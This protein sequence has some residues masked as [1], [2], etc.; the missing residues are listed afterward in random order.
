MLFHKLC[1]YR[2]FYQF[3]TSDVVMGHHFSS[4]TMTSYISIMGCYS[5]IHVIHG[6]PLIMN[7]FVWV[8]VRK[9]VQNYM[10]HK[11][12]VPEMTHKAVNKLGI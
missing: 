5:Q 10:K 7:G 9:C 12:Q 3:Q 6:N 11:L 2:K 1:S 4:G 8:S